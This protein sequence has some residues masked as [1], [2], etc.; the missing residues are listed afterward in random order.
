MVQ[1]GPK[2]GLKCQQ[3]VQILKV[4]INGHGDTAD[5][6]RGF[7]I[8]MLSSYTFHLSIFQSMC[9]TCLRCSWY[10]DIITSKLEI[11]HQLFLTCKSSAYW[12]A[13]WRHWKCKL[14]RQLWTLNRVIINR[15]QRAK[16]SETEYWPKRV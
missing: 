14:N 5:M 15:S 6:I 11:C 7:I 12:F 3:I 10:W 8:T 1:S 2:H 16:L 13:R 9:Y 4:Q